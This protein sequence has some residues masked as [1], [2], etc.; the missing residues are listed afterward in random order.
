MGRAL[1]KVPFNL[2]QAGET[3]VV[4][5]L[6][7]WPN[8]V[9]MTTDSTGVQ[10]VQLTKK[11]AAKAAAPLAAPSAVAAQ[12]VA[13]TPVATPPPTAPVVVTTATPAVVA[14]GSVEGSEM[15]KT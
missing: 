7:K 9:E 11:N 2:A 8:K 5:F 4:T 14:A 15:L 12:V 13:A 6:S 3:N 10:V 1:W